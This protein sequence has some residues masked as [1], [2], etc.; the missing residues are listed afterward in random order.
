MRFLRL[1]PILLVFLADP[2]LAQVQTQQ[3]LQRLDAAI[4]VCTTSA[5]LA[6]NQ[7]ET[8]TCTPPAGQFVY[9]A[10]IA[11]DVCTNG[12]G[13]AA[14]Q[15]TWTTTNITGSPTFGFSIAA[16]ASICQ[17]WSIPLPTPLKSTV[18]GTAVTFVSPAAATNNSYH[19][20]VVVSYGP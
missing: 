14:N 4:A 16:T 2:A 7:Q 1:L 6:I 13:T 9:I 19:A 12:T 10:T 5:A 18:A 11:F 15:V 8:V 20:T 17:H 3:T